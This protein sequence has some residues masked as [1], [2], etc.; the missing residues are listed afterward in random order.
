VAFTELPQHLGLPSLHAADRHWE[1]FFQACDETG[2]VICVHIGSGSNPLESADD[3]PN[4]AALSLTTVT[5][6]L[7]LTDW[8]M[9]GTLSRF[10]NIKVAMSESQVGWMPFQLQR[11]DVVWRNHKEAVIRAR[12]PRSRQNVA[13]AE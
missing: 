8:L 11:L 1:R 4:A 6:Q 3:G 2:T 13:V 7:S 5:S 9:A 10:P 12:V